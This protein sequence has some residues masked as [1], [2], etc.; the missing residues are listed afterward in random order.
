MA[1][2]IDIFAKNL[3]LTDAIKG[4]IE[5]KVSKLD[6]FMKEV[7]ETRFDIFRY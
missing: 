3:E 2:K 6:R 5:K 7:T 4:Y 1:V